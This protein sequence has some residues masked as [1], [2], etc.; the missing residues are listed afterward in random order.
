MAVTDIDPKLSRLYHE[1]ST[2][3]PPPA[4]D[5]V[6]VAAARQR[7]GTPLRRQPRSS[8]SRWMLPVSVLATLVLGVSLTFLVERESPQTTGTTEDTVTPRIPAQP[9]RPS[10]TLLTEPEKAKAADAAPPGITP[11]NEVPAVAGPGQMVLPRPTELAPAPS[12]TAVAA[13]QLA[14]EK[15]LLPPAAPA[16]A[17]PASSPAA[18]AFPAEI[19]TRNTESGLAKEADAARDTAAGAASLRSSTSAADSAKAAPARLQATQRSPESWLEEIRR[20]RQEGREKQ[21]MEQ[22]AEFRKAYP[23]YPVPDTLLK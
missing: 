13:G 9:Q 23:A 22:L 3:G 11:R 20:L 8:W 7:V 15:K 18:V 1:A 6:I 16:A 14:S 17:P 2:D 19:G 10:A 5:A 21:A 4:L 12:G